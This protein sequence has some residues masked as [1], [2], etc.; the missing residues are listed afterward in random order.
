[1]TW[2]EAVAFA[3]T[4]P[5]AEMSTSYGSP[6][7]KAN[8]NSFMGVSR[9]GATS[10]GLYMDHGLIAAMM[11]M[12]PETFWKT[13]HYEGYPAV[14]VRYDTPHD[15]VVRDMIERAHARALAKK[16]PKPRKKR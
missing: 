3:L 8:G 7:I 1:M 4:L 15:D 14:L 5:G 11:D 16:P 9:E 13:P 12:Y 6:A 10:F 2:E